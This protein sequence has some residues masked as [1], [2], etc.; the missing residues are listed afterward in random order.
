MRYIFRS[1]G[2]GQPASAT[3]IND[4]GTSERFFPGSPGW[5]E[6]VRW[7]DAGNEPGRPPPDVVLVDPNSV[8]ERLKALEQQVE[9]LIHERQ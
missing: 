9:E 8:E 6:F 5:Q 1:P 2:N 7:R 4:D 3:R